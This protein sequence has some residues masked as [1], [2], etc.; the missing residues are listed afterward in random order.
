MQRAFQDSALSIT[1]SCHENVSHINVVVF[2]RGQLRHLDVVF[3]RE[4][5]RTEASLHSVEEQLDI[6]N[7]NVQGSLSFLTVGPVWGFARFDA[8]ILLWVADSAPQIHWDLCNVTGNDTRVIL[9]KQSKS[10]EALG[11]IRTRPIISWLSNRELEAIA[12]VDVVEQAESIGHHHG[13]ISLGRAI[14]VEYFIAWLG[15]M[16]Q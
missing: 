11:C 15:A 1:V 4:Q 13:F 10:A 14:I 16:S 8:D 7:S 9:A 12:I 5:K 3:S 2:C 6:L